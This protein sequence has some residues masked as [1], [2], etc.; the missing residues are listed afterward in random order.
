MS[1][2]QFKLKRKRAKQAQADFIARMEAESTNLNNELYILWQEVTDRL[3]RRHKFTP[4]DLIGDIS[5]YVEDD[6]EGAA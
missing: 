5:D 2:D 3:I 4:A 1:D 6:D